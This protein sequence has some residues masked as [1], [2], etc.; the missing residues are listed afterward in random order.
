MLKALSAAAVLAASLAPAKEPPVLFPAPLSPRNASYRIDVGLDA[1]KHLL[2]ATE[3]I[4]WRNLTRDDVPDLAFHLYMNAFSSSETLFM[5]ESE[6][7][8][9]SARFDEK[10]WGYVEVSSLRLVRGGREVALTQEFPGPDRTVMRARLPEPVHPGGEIEVRAAF[11]VQLPKVF[12]RT[13]W[14][15]RFHI[16]GQ[17]FPKLGVYQ[18]GKG[19][20]CY[21]FH[22]STEF[23]S[24]FGVYDVSIEVPRDYVVG[25]TGVLWD[26]REGPDGRKTLFAH[27][28]DVHDFA[29]AA[30]PLFVERVER[31][32]DVTLRLLMQP[33]N[34]DSTSRYFEAAHRALD[35]YAR[36][37][38]PY[39][40]SQLTV[41]DP[42]ADG[43]GASGM[44]Y[45]TF[46]TGGTGPLV[47]PRIRIPELVIVHEVGHQ[48]WYGMSANNEFEEP[49]LDEGINSYY[50][51]RVMDEWFGASTSA[52]EDV[53]GFSA[54][55]LDRQRAG[56]LS[57]ARSAPVLT[58]PWEFPSFG[59][60]GGITYFKS[61][62]ILRT[63]EEA[64]GRAAVDRALAA[65]FER[66][67]FRHPT[68]ADALDAIRDRLGPAAAALTRSLLEGTGTI[69]FEVEAV[70][71][72]RED[73]R[74]GF[75]LRK[76]PPARWP[77]PTATAKDPNGG[78]WGSE[79]W[80]VRRGSV[81]LPVS[82][83]VG[84]A[85]GTSKTETWDG[86][87]ASK[88]FRYHGPNVTSVDVDPG[89]RVVLEERRLDNGW[90]A[91]ADPGPARALVNRCLFLLQ[92]LFAALP[93]LI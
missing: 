46:I 57:V 24:D 13:G 56:Y 19:W 80:I 35:F 70:H 18:E 67:R 73:A 81:V 60:Y 68:T 54:G 36:T 92:G 7:R 84:F 38:G 37:I 75:D 61:S 50:E 88:T 49:W 43:Q 25:T 30:S 16:A 74:S 48:F 11:D 59:V 26:E 53:L 5:K 52:V 20:N 9:R 71:S 44:E 77:E 1:E 23:F 29:W 12:A 6:G 55:S 83:R 65:F 8:H 4:R 69:D 79:V 51:M 22:L 3:T 45:P 40:Y 85:D 33:E 86:V 58:R 17:W 90:R 28:E 21:P 31:W 78:S 87:G 32:R 42:P 72:R 39:P 15:G 34:S 82:V 76:S 89:G 66:A 63:L 27:A 41:V 62:L 93:A 14:A 91:E 10:D 2:H 47:S 64:H